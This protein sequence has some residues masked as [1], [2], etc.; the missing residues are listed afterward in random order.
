MSYSQSPYEFY[1]NTILCVRANYLFE[2][3]CIITYD[4]YKKLTQRGSLNLIRKARGKYNYALV[5][6]ESMRPD[7]KEK[8]MEI[9]P[10]TETKK[11]T[12]EKYIKPDTKAIK[13]FSSFRKE[14]GQPLSENLQKKYATNAILLNA[15]QEMYGD[16]YG[17]S[18]ALNLRTSLFWQNLS[19]ALNEL[20]V[21]KWD[22]NLPGTPRA[23]KDAMRS[24]KK[25]SY[26]SL[27]PKSVG[28]ANT[29]KIKGEIADFLLGM[30]CQPNKPTVTHVHLK[31]N[32]VRE[33][34]NWP[35]I[36]EQAI[37][38]FLKKPANERIWVLARHGKGKWENKFGY[39]IS[40]DRSNWFPNAI[41]AIDGSKLDWIFIDDNK[42]VAK[43]KINILLDVYSE[44]ILGYSISEKEEIRDHFKAIKM[45][46][47]N[48]SSRPYLLL[49]DN[50]S[51]HKSKRMQQLYT[52]IVAQEGGTHYPNK[53]YSH[54]NPME[55]VFSRLQKH[56][57]NQ[58]WFSDKQ[59]I[60][61]KS[62]DSHAN[63]DFIVENKHK[64]FT[65]D[66]C[67]ALFD[68]MVQEWNQSAHPNKE[69][70][71]DD[72]Y[73]ESMTM[74]EPITL[75]DKLTMFWLEETK[76]I[77]Y[78]AHGIQVTINGEKKLFE[79][80]DKDDC[81][82]SDF[83]RKYIGEKFI[84]RY[85][86][87]EPDGFIQLLLVQDNG[88]KAH[89]ANAQPKHVHEQVPALMKEGAKAYFMKDYEVKEKEL[90]AD[91]EEIERVRNSTGISPDDL[92]EET[93]L[94]LKYGGKIP[95]EDRSRAETAVSEL[96]ALY[97]I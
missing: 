31:Y 67:I 60:K 54:S 15:L 61:S 16:T 95:K 28:N 70:S 64:L 35:T 87:D 32:E 59:S 88:Q 40:R 22:H 23:L 80:Y 18:I 7:I 96:S 65:K 21:D 62:D 78:R 36:T 10:P 49:Y 46:V 8:V 42:M 50:Q 75:E 34:R 73:E 9:C 83:R 39:K 14:S 13:F 79:V 81:V 57:L 38:F 93:E 26:E 53:A 45:A 37:S 3:A 48:T 94:M 97:K 29:Q 47:N 11:A 6:F 30:Y 90:Q 74:Q 56:L 43:L 66:K 33:S 82:D 24:Y 76:P 85:D 41:W 84:V 19:D 27:I 4:A 20:P 63:M 77:T 1:D 5:E 44:K 68:V 17:R 71:R 91:L 52:D 51:G 92:I 86:P 12:L 58:V 55:Q 69:C 72:V 89:V 25:G 2:E